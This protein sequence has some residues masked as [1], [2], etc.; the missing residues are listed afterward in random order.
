MS[1]YK[2]INFPLLGVDLSFKFL[3]SE[4]DEEEEEDRKNK[5]CM[6]C[7]KVTGCLTETVFLFFDLTAFVLG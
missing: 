4:E 2:Q 1:E 3:L 5:H 6:F 7:A